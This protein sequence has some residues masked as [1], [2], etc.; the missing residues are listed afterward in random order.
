MA[1]AS[2]LKHTTQ[3]LTPQPR[4]P[5][6]L[7]PARSGTA[8][9]ERRGRLQPLNAA[10]VSVRSRFLQEAGALHPFGFL[11][12]STSLCKNAA[13]QLKKHLVMIFLTCWFACLV[14]WFFFFF[15]GKFND[16]LIVCQTQ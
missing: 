6:P 7:F 13:N 10:F 14:V 3:P 12:P 11:S 15:E 1:A 16:N 4:P 5:P 9:S 2:R 8:G